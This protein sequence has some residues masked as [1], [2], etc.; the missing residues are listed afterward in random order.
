MAR[1]TVYMYK[2][3]GSTRKNIDLQSVF[4]H[5]SAMTGYIDCMGFIGKNKQTNKTDRQESFSISFFIIVFCYC[6]GAVQPDSSC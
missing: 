1:T 3:H 6:G 2:G 5:F 4:S